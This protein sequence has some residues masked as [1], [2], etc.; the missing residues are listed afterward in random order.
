MRGKSLKGKGVLFVTATRIP[1]ANLKQEA[2]IS[3]AAQED[4][5]HPVG[6][7][8][9]GAG[10]KGSHLVRKQRTEPGSSLLFHVS[11]RQAEVSFLDHSSS[12]LSDCVIFKER[13]QLQAV[14][15]LSSLF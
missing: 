12:T 2:L 15:S 7:G 11:Q 1:G 9:G 13:C 10:G 8:G 6:E 14:L 3:A 5:V 4:R